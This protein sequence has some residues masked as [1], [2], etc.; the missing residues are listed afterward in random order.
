MALQG[1]CL[2]FQTYH[3]YLLEFLN[4]DFNT[5][6]KLLLGEG[7]LSNTFG[8]ADLNKLTP[9]EIV[10]LAVIYRQRQTVEMPGIQRFS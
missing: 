3:P 6:G 8:L 2:Q 5:F 10:K 4:F 7:C 1:K 9:P